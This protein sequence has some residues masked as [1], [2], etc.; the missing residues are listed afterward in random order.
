MDKFI[1]F[2]IDNK[3]TLACV[4]QKGRKE[5]LASLPSKVEALRAFRQQEKGG[6]HQQARSQRRPLARRRERLA[7]HQTKPAHSWARH[8]Q[9][10]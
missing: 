3:K 8:N 5:R 1:G 9:P 6:A 2:D 7:R 10:V 4:V